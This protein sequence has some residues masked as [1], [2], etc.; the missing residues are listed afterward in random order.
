[1]IPQLAALAAA[2]TLLVTAVPAAE[3]TAI[4][5]TTCTKTL[6]ELPADSETGPALVRTADPSGRYLL[7]HASRAGR[8]MS[9]AVLWV[10]GVPRWLASRPDSESYAYAVVDGGFVLGTSVDWT[11]T[12]FWI[13]SV[14]GD[15]YRILQPPKDLDIYLVTAM[16]NRQ[17]IAGLAWDANHE[18][19][20]P[21]VW[22]AGGQPRLL[23][24]PKGYEA[25]S[26]DG[27][28]DEGRIIGSLGRSDGFESTSYLWKSWNTRPTRLRG[29]NQEAVWARDIEGVW[30]GGQQNAGLEQPGLVWNTTNGRITKLE[31][32]VADVNSSGDAVTD[33]AYLID[34]YPSILARSNGTRITFPDG[35]L[36]EHVF[37]RGSQWTAAGSEVSSGELRPVLYDCGN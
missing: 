34:S 16:N 13:Y 10:D 31:H 14:E 5:R 36:L 2:T 28:S 3:S 8:Q 29:L 22:P 21:F 1:M 4:G 6:L 27:I 20:L 33:G 7:G 11:S 26:L 24:M 30:I 19:T 32:G 23:P 18:R 35:T 15:S 12:D 9:Q 37:D 17:D 25:H